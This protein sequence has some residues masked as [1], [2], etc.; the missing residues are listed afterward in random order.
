M[1]EVIDSHCHLDFKHFDKDREEVI[2]RARA[3]GVVQMVNSGVDLPTNRK[4]LALA[5]K[6][7]FIRPTLGLSPNGIEKM[8]NRDLEE[9][10]S[11]IRDNAGEIVGVGE[12]GLDTY[13]CKDPGIRKR[14]VEYFQKMIDLARE[15]DLPLVIHARDTEQQAFDMVKE[16]EKVVFHCYSGS[17]A[18]LKQILDRGFYVSI[19]T[20]ICRSVQ[21]QGLARQCSLDQLLIET[22]S[23]FLSPRKGRNEPSFVLDSVNLISRLKG[24]TPAEVAS[25]TTRNVRKIYGL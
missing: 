4:T 11:Y 7:D 3:A 12:A 2:D 6:Y 5:R 1:D 21:H 14:Q 19:A 23:P 8:G 16:L 10:I 22:D 18:T 24:T 17:M 9:V 20:V 13:R 15:L 25:A